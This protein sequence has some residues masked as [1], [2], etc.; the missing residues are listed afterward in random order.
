[1]GDLAYNISCRGSDTTNFGSIES[2][3]QY[4]SVGM[5]CLSSQD[6]GSRT[7]GFSIRPTITF[8]LVLMQEIF[9]ADWSNTKKH[10]LLLVAPPRI[11]MVHISARKYL[12]LSLYV[13]QVS[14][15]GILQGSRNLGLSRS[16]ARLLRH[17]LLGVTFAPRF[18]FAPSSTSTPPTHRPATGAMQEL[19]GPTPRQ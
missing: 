14:N 6:S 15:N 12:G 7:C 1:M 17:F 5:K 19:G 18:M 9:G 8:D 3:I 11:N 2:I 10:F 16:D 4:T 13:D